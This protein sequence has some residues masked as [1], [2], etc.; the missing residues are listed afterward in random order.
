MS[1]MGLKSKED[2]FRRATKHLEQALDN[3]CLVQ[4]SMTAVKDYMLEALDWFRAGVALIPDE[5]QTIQKFKAALVESLQREEGLRARLAS[6][7]AAEFK[8]VEKKLAESLQREKALEAKLTYSAM[9]ELDEECKEAWR[10]LRESLQREKDLQR[11]VILYVESEQRL[12]A[13][14]ENLLGE[15]RKLTPSGGHAEPVKPS[16]PGYTADGNWDVGPAGPVKPPM[17]WTIPDVT[18]NTEPVKPAESKPSGP[19]N[20]SVPFWWA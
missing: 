11:Q 20:I 17:Q 18:C 5:S 9:G 3:V 2:Y 6:S 8:V 15:A 13:A 10:K 4:D 19:P 1:D 12:V 14:L 16:G 7:E